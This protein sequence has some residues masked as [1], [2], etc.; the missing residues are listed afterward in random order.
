MK[1]PLTPEERSARMRLVPAKDTKPELLVRKLIHA[2][3]YRYRLHA[4]NLP[5]TPD[6][7]F[8]GRKKVIFMHGCMW[9]GH[10]NCRLN[11]P[12]GNRQE[13][14]LPK[15]ERNK[16]RDEENRRKLEELGWSVFIVWECETRR[17]NIAALLGRVRDFLG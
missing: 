8:A 1:D 10:E 13:Y 5:G 15:L 2:M 12:P 11:R 17:K 16:R 7:V 14:W 6:M 9:H 4:R 3:G